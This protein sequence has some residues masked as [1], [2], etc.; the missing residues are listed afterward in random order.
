MPLDI[1]PGQAVPIPCRHCTQSLIPFTLSEGAHALSCPR[2]GG[3]T[4]V[5]VARE[6]TDLRVR[7]AR[8]RKR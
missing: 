2:C 5:K 7:T 6:G 8:A 3:V 4:D 1:R